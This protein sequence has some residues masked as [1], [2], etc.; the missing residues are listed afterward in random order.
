VAR[1][2]PRRLCD[3]EESGVARAALE[4]LAENFSDGVVA[5]A[6][7]TVL[8][9]LPGLVVYKAI[10]TA[11]SMIGHRTPRLL[12]FGWAAARADDGVNWLPARIAG[13]L[14]CPAGRGGSALHCW[15]WQAAAWAS[16]NAGPVMA[17]GAG[18]LRVRLGGAAVYHGELEQ[19]PSLGCGM[20]A[21]AADIARAVQ[22]VRH[23]LFAWLLVIAAGGL[24]AAGWQHA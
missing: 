9:G 3:R 12:R 14:I 10:N 24:V 18:A 21:G 5:P 16:P 17:S 4:S 6:F 7:W 15:R 8:L 19:R 11:D 23:A 22:L 13:G 2:F 1:L 20:A